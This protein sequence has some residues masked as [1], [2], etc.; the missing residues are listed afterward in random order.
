MC[1]H[2]PVPTLHQTPAVLV[3]RGEQPASPY[4][5]R[6]GSHISHSPLYQLAWDGQAQVNFSWKT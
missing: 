6:V 5:A 1:K 2:F 4:P 3:V